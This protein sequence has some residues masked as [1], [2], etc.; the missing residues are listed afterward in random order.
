MNKSFLELNNNNTT[1]KIRI[2][3]PFIEPVNIC[4]ETD[5]T[6]REYLENKFN[7]NKKSGKGTYFYDLMG[8]FETYCQKKNLLCAKIMAYYCSN[9]ILK[10]NMSDDDKYNL[11][12]GM[13]LELLN[14]GDNDISGL[15]DIEDIEDIENIENIDIK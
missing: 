12:V 10:T 4:K 15:N 14:L 8:V 3:N 11:F 6:I 2:E 1:C 9:F 7:E 5:K 13:K